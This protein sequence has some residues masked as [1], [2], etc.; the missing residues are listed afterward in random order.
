MPPIPFQSVPFK[1]NKNKFPQRKPKI[2][3]LVRKKIVIQEQG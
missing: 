3:K 1:V 2:P